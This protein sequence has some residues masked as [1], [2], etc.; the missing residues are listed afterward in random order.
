MNIAV[1]RIAKILGIAL[2]IVIAFAQ[3][4]ESSLQS[5]IE[6]AEANFSS[7][8]NQLQSESTALRSAGVRTLYELSF[9]KLPPEPETGLNGFFNNLISWT[10]DRG[11]YRLLERGRNLFTGYIRTSNTASSEMKLLS[12]TLAKTAVSWSQNELEI[13]GS[14]EPTNLWFF[15]EAQLPYL[16]YPNAPLDGLNAS[17][18]NFTSADLSYAHLESIYAPN[19]VFIEADLDGARAKESHF[20]GSNLEDAS[21]RH[22]K[23]PSS[24]FRNCNMARADFSTAFLHAAD[25]SSSILT[26]ANFSSAELVSVDFSNSKLEGADFSGANLKLANF[27]NADLRNADFRFARGLA[28]V[29]TFKGAIVDRA[30]FPENFTLDSKR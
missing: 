26:D 5:R 27:E 1:V 20:A 6:S 18:A 11:D 17:R 10:L 29:E 8:I 9:R 2:P 25:F 4:L 15:F 24:V 28:G 22:F 21:L 13:D 14:A 19:A 30:F 3:Y 7:A 23:G 16:H 12:T